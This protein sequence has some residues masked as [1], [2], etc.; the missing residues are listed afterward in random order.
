MEG[1]D[2]GILFKKI[3]C[4]CTVLDRLQRFLHQHLQ[5]E[6]P[7]RRPTFLGTSLLAASP[8]RQPPAYGSASVSPPFLRPA[9]SPLRQDLRTPLRP[10]SSALQSPRRSQRRSRRR[11]TRSS[12]R[13]VVAESICSRAT[14][15]R[16]HRIEQPRPASPWSR[17]RTADLI[18]LRSKISVGPRTAAGSRRGGRGRPLCRLWAAPAPPPRGSVGR[19][20][21]RGAGG[22]IRA[23]LWRGRAGDAVCRRI[24][25]GDDAPVEELGGGPG[26]ADLG[27]G[28]AGPEEALAVAGGGGGGW[29]VEVAGAGRCSATAGANFLTAARRDAV[30]RWMPPPFETQ[31]LSFICSYLMQIR[32]T[33]RENLSK[34]L[35]ATY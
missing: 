11:R 16:R 9:P 7:L 10:C 1:C 27:G 20:V 17:H 15:G 34:K 30:H 31:D 6:H 25:A 18:T 14:G 4:W 22:R 24:R 3:M 5:N 12:A 2:A 21:R 23:P 32:L 29:P 35:N 26:S 19:R 13:A 8:H 33:A 28:G